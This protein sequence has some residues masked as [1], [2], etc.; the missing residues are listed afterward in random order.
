[1][2]EVV[3]RAGNP[4][5]LALPLQQAYA[6]AVARDR[7]FRLVLPCLEYRPFHVSLGSVGGETIDLCVEGEGDEPVVLR[8]MSMSLLGRRIELSNF[9]LRGTRTPESA[10]T[11]QVVDSFAGERLGFMEICRHDS[12]SN[13]PVV[14]VSAIGDRDRNAS[15]VLRECWFIA[16]EGEG[17]TATLSTPKTGRAHITR[18]LIQRCAFMGNRTNVCL[19]PWFTRKLELEGLFVL[20]NEVDAWLRLR[21][22]LVEVTVVESILSSA[23]TLVEFLTGPDAARKDFPPVAASNCRVLSATPVSSHYVAGCDNT[24]GTPLPSPSG[25]EEIIRLGGRPLNQETLESVLRK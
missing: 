19:D 2:S 15:A 6:E 10:L 9:V 11:V 24:A 5:D 1:M 4:G 14:Q 8:G 7:S 13:E 20:E 22:Q 23:S 12:M 3:F 18:L 21:S 25:W 16:N 17:Y